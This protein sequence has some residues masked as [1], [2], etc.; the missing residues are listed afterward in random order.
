MNEKFSWELVHCMRI[1]H[2]AM[3]TPVTRN[4]NSMFYANPLLQKAFNRIW[5]IFLKTL[6]CRRL[7][8]N[9][10]WAKAIERR[11]SVLRAYFFIQATCKRTR[12]ARH[13]TKIYEHWQGSMQRALVNNVNQW[14]EWWHK[15]TN[16]QAHVLQYKA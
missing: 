7:S 10:A 16:K 11:L 15:Y 3:I 2:R 5:I 9:E 14:S 13:G 12:E 1:R 8:P 6:I 4:S